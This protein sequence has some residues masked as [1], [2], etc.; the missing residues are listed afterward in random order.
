MRVGNAL[1]GVTCLSV[2]VGYVVKKH[3]DWMSPSSDAAKRMLVHQLSFWG[4]TAMALILMHR[5]MHP[6]LGILEKLALCFS[7]AIL[8]IFGFEGGGRLGK[9]LY[10]KQTHYNTPPTTTG[11]V[12]HP[13]YL[14]PSAERRY[15]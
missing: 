12:Y 5:A 3:M 9:L 1:L 4:T 6:R 15:A 13:G 14:S 2:P 7:T 10:P 8:P 11:R